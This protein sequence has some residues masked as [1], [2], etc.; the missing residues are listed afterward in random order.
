[1]DIATSFDALHRDH[2]S[3]CSQI[4]CQTTPT[5]QQGHLDDVLAVA[6]TCETASHPSHLRNVGFDRTVEPVGIV[7][8]DAETGTAVRGI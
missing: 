7:G 5:I 2:R 8:H 3:G 1:L 4:K 6:R